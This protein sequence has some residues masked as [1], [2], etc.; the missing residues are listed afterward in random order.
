VNSTVLRANSKDVEFIMISDKEENYI[1]LSEHKG[2]D[3]SF[4]SVL[5][6]NTKV[7]IRN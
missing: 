3:V 5:I 1:P 7:I 6:Y 2:N 4:V